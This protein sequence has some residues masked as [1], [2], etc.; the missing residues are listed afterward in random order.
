MVGATSEFSQTQVC[1]AI[2]R[3]NTFEELTLSKFQRPL[4]NFDEAVHAKESGAQEGKLGSSW[5]LGIGWDGRRG[6]INI[7]SAHEL[8]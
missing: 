5:G 4:L 3:Q 6:Q 8:V 1:C 7:L 2:E